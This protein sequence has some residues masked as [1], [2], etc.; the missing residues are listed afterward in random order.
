MGEL[1][2]M[3]ALM[4]K[5]RSMVP[6]FEEIDPAD[7]PRRKVEMY[8]RTPGNRHL[9]DGYDCPVCLNRGDLM[10]LEGEGANASPVVRDCTCVNTRNMIARMRRSGLKNIITDYTFEKFEA[11]EPWQEA[12]KTAAKEYA[13]SGEGW[14]FIGGQSGSGKTHICTAICRA[15]L[16]K[17]KAVQYMLWRDDVVPLKAA[18]TES[19]EYTRTIARYKNADVLYIDD[20]FK[21]GK[22]GNGERQRPTAAD[23]NVAFEI[24][25]HRYNA[26]LPTIISSECTTADL[27]DI[28]EAVAGRIL[29]R[30]KVLNLKPD[31]SRNYR[32][33]MAVDL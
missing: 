11:K 8:N 13:V 20:L 30:A 5:M 31:R 19:D 17:G 23:V 33:K 24:L 12:L 22:N 14:F 25:N 28:D 16:N 21:T 10:R 7:L 9:D 26:K 6:G 32:L 4:N 29:E 1:V 3:A 18:V 2:S 27:L 15:F